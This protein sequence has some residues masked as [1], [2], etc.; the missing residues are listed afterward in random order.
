MGDFG[1]IFWILFLIIALQ[2]VLSRRLLES[3]RIRL[4]ARI[5]R[6]RNSKVILL[7]HRQ[8]SMSL[9]GFPVVRYISM[10]DSE[11]VL[12]ALEMTPANKNIDLVL[13]TPGGLVLAA[14][15]IARAISRHQGKVRVIIPHYA[16]SGG[17]LIALAADEIIMSPNAVLGPLDPQLGE[18]PAP[19]LIRLKELKGTEKIDDKTLILIDL[20]EKAT[21]QLRRTIEE[22]LRKNYPAEQ[23]MELSKILTEGTWTHDYPIDYELAKRLGLNVSNQIPV[24]FMQLMTLYPQPVRTRSVEYL[25]PSQREGSPRASV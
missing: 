23:A 16:M 19:S 3:A 20:A 9:L 25:E 7:I 2:P 10:E 8:E 24:E 13:H 17:T 22:L 12:R 11:E 14:T 4:L 5:E 18:Y 6:M 21:A 1:I 15:Q